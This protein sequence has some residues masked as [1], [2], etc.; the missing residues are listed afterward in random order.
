MN[1]KN[2]TIA[3]AAIAGTLA[4]GA[5]LTADNSTELYGTYSIE[6]ERYKAVITVDMPDEFSPDICTLKFNDF[7]VDKEL[8]PNG[9]FVVYP[10][11]ADEPERLTLECTVKGEEAGVAEFLSDGRIKIYAKEKYV[12]ELE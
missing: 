12:K 4:T 7:D 8:L 11:L 1:I 10:L 2:K 3:A 6:K 9:E 5:V